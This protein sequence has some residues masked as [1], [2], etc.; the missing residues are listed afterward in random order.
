VGI[1][2]DDIRQQIAKELIDYR[3]TKF[4]ELTHELTRNSTEGIIGLLQRPRAVDFQK[5]LIDFKDYTLSLDRA[6]NQNIADV[7]NRLLELINGI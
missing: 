3:D 2:P 4:T 5:Q 1:L 7:D 6:R